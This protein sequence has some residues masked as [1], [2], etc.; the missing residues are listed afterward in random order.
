MISPLLSHYE[1]LALL[2][3]ELSLEQLARFLAAR[4][5]R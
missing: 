3:V 2:V 5:S 4:Q 1:P